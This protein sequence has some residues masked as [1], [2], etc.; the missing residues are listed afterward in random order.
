MFVTTNKA[1][2]L[3]YTS[4]FK[5]IPQ[6]EVDEMLKKAESKATKEIAAVRDQYDTEIKLKESE[7][8]RL[9]DTIK[10]LTSERDQ[11]ETNLKELNAAITASN[12]LKEKEVK[13]QELFNK[14]HISDNNVNISSNDVRTSEAKR[15]SAETESQYKLWHLVAA[16]TIPVV[17]VLALE[18]FKKLSAKNIYS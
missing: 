13:S 16:A 8:K 11:L 15:E 1:K 4:E 10:N 7:I 5:R 17:G 3:R 14:S 9:S 18:A 12:T 6:S 2:A